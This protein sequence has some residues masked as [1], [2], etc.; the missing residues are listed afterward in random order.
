MDIDS[1]KVL[2]SVLRS[3]DKLILVVV[4]INAS[5]YNDILCTLDIGTHWSFSVVNIPTL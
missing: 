5:G 4:N 1:S 2:V 3:L